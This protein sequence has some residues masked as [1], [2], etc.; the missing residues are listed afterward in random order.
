MEKE[1]GM[2]NGE[3]RL[4]SGKWRVENLQ[5]PPFLPLQIGFYNGEKFM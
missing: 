1:W 4:K 2:E 3:W 5:K